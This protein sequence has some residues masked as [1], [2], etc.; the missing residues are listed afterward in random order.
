[1]SNPGS[2]SPTPPGTQ[3]KVK[4]LFGHCFEITRLEEGDKIPVKVISIDDM[5]R[6]NLSAIEAGFKPK[7]RNSKT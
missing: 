4:Q 7:S 5:G 1:M 3:E 2:W 6:I